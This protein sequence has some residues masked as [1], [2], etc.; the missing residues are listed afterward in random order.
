MQ[1]MIEQEQ[2]TNIITMSKKSYNSDF[3]IEL[4]NEELDNIPPVFYEVTKDQLFELFVSNKITQNQFV[5]ISNVIDTNASIN[6]SKPQ[7]N[8]KKGKFQYPFINDKDT[9]IKCHDNLKYLMEYNDINI[10]YNDVSRKI[11]FTGTNKENVNHSITHLYSLAHKNGLKI[12]KS[13]VVDFAELISSDNSYNPVIEYLEKAMLYWDGVSRLKELVDTLITDD[14]EIDPVLK[15]ELVKAWLVSTVRITKNTIYNPINSEGL[16]VLQGKQGIGKTEWIKS[17][18]PQE[19]RTY[20]KE[21]VQLDVNNKDSVY[22][23]TCN[24]I[25]ELGELDGTLKREQASL[26]AF[27]TSE[28]DVQRRPYAIK[29]EEFPRTTSFFGTVNNAEFLQDETGDRRYWVIPIKGIKYEKLK[30]FDLMQLWGEAMNILMSEHNAHKLSEEIREMLN[31]S[32]ASYRVMSNVQI[33][34]QAHFDW[35]AAKEEWQLLTSSDI[36]NK[37]DLK[38]SKGLRQAIEECGGEYKRTKTMRGYLVPPFKSVYN[39]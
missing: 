4:S 27:F 14:T 7:E 34:V 17:L 2:P 28:L 18:I 6:V 19:L 31:K 12:S 1:S 36:A 3:K 23:A 9:P 29:E 38:T 30:E 25:C 5:H 11:E 21:G 15:F 13:D 10:R 39:I 26:K 20:F 24:W 16:L 22:Q 35:N 32:N 37:L 33:K 8:P